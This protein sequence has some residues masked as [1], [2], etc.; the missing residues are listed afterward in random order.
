MSTNKLIN[1]LPDAYRKDTESNNYKLLDLSETAIDILRNDIADITQV[2]D[3]ASASGETL[4]LFGEMLG[5]KRGQ[6]DDEK[7]RYSLLTQIGQNTA[8]CDFN[9]VL[10]T[11]ITMFSLSPGDV[12]YEDI[13]ITE[14]ETSGNINLLKLPLAVLNKAGF[15]PKQAINLVRDI[16]PIGVGIESA[17]FEG[18]F[19]FAATDTEYDAEKGFG[20][21]TDPD[22]GGTLGALVDY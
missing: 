7:Y 10:N 22:I 14:S 19:E 11:M 4:D 2:V 1:K 16:L 3:I 12:T 15:S 9:S 5:R 13:V 6:L 18:S 17:N 20:S 8:H 21:L